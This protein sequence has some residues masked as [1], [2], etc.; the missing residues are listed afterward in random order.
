M[1]TRREDLSESEIR[2]LHQARG[3]YMV[4][5]ELNWDGNECVADDIDAGEA[6]QD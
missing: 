3:Y 6:G 5:D 1:K 2:A 4:A